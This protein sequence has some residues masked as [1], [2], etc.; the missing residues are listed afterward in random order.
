[1]TGLPEACADLAGW[2]PA[3]AAL[4]AEP[5]AG[6]TTAGGGP[7]TAS[8]PPWNSEVAAAL[9]DAHEGVRRLEASLRLAVTGR[10]GRRR[11]GSDGN[12]LAALDAIGSLGEAVGTGAASVAAR[13]LGR[14]TTAWEQLPAV[15]LTETPRKV[16]A[17]CPYCDFPMMR[18]FPRSGRVT[19]LRFG[20]CEDSDG[21]HPVGHLRA[22]RLD[23]SACVEWADGLVT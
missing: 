17:R 14:W 22:S 19:C 6:D 12:T 13:L 8:R 15:D 23:G 18:V 3:A 10:A 9:Y 1:V 20:N 7:A 2:L 5:D 4:L 16:T 21:N 11:G